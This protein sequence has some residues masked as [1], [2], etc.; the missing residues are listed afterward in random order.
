MSQWRL[1]LPECKFKNDS[2]DLLKDQ[3]IFG[4][5]NKD[6]Q[7]HLLGEISE[8]DNSVKALYKARKIES[9]LEQCKLLGIVKPDS[10][11]DVNVVK[12]KVRFQKVHDCD[13]CGCSYDRGRLPCLWQNLQQMWYER[14]TLLKKCKQI[15]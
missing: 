15:A 6:I 10:L 1:A 3:F 11:V 8:T 4:I 5:E 14:T 13:Y 7:D 9:K 2:D 12:K